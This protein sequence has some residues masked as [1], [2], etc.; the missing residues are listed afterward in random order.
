MPDT[1]RPGRD[2]IMEGS[3]SP[4][5]GFL[6]TSLSTQCPSKYQPPDPTNNEASTAPKNY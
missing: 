3:Y 4:N 5:E 6:A 2:V 1:L